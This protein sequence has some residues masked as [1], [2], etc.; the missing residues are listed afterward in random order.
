MRIGKICDWRELTLREQVGQMLILNSAGSGGMPVGGDELKAFLVQYPIGGIFV[1]GEVIVDGHNELGWVQ[2]RVEQI[3]TNLSIPLLVSADLENGA[4]D[5]IPG[6]TPLPYP[7]ALGAAEDTQLA[8]D[9]GKACAVEGA[10]AC[11][12]WALAPMSD[13]N[14]HPLSSN[15][16]Q[17]AFGDTAERVIPL[18]NAFIEGAQ[19]AGM[20]A[21]AKT[22]PGDGSDYRDQHL[23]T[24]SNRLS[25]EDWHASYGKVFKANIEAGVAT[26]MTGH[27]TFPAYQRLFNDGK[28]PPATTCPELT[29]RL[30]KQELGFKGVVVTDAFGMGGILTHGDTINAAV[31]AFA[32]GADMFLWPDPKFV[33]EAVR[34]LEVGEI[35]MSRLEDAM[36]RIWALKRKYCKPLKVESDTAIEFG[37]SVARRTAEGGLTQLWNYD[38]RLPLNSEK[39]PRVLLVG[40]TPHDK[41]YQRFEILADDL[42]ERG[43]KVDQIRHIS[44]QEIR[45]KEPNYDILL[46]CIERQFHRPLGPMDFFGEDSRNLWAACLVG[47]EKTVAV[48]FGSPYLV[49]WYF[50]EASAALNVYSVVP[51]CQHAVAAALCGEIACTGVDP[52]VWKGRYCVN[53]LSEISQP[54]WDALRD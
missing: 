42:R 17:R 38:Q 45:E 2:D 47:R 46:F 18:L 19:D 22:F 23:V 52:V 44:P 14:L 33:D 37:Q 16:G 39:E 27:L 35:P 41:A 32:A 25:M 43:F 15:V 9:Y 21:C 28:L 50:E 1:G 29:N 7:M 30:L 4:G 40:T 24:T 31:D 49:P 8:Y 5:V 11:V 10:L 36:Q 6:L 53:S 54:E 48:G 12:N 20:A 3:Q 26:I 51:A 34:R 13:L